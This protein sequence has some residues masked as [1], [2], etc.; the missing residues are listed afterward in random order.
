ML[1]SII[2]GFATI[3]IVLLL[4]PV[5]VVVYQEVYDSRRPVVQICNYVEYRVNETGTGYICI[6]TARE[7]GLV[8]HPETGLWMT[9]EGLQGLG[10][11]VALDFSAPVP[12]GNPADRRRW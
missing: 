11:Q 7:W 8:P 1:S 3:L 6:K 5:G 4:I 12:S 9:P 10:P 2:K